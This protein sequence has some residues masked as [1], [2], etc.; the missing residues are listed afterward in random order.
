MREISKRFTFEAA[1]S[2]PKHKGLCS[3]VHGHSYKLEVRVTGGIMKAE[4]NPEWGMIMDFSDLKNIVKETVLD[5]HDHA[6]LNDIYPNPTAEN[7]VASMAEAII[8]K[9]P[10]GRDLT[11]LKLWETEDS[12]AIWRNPNL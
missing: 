3:K 2:L 4:N 1:H 5:I 6:Y 10:M 8:E 7:M 11:V 12:Y 9:L